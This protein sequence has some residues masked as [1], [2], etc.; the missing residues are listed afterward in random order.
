MHTGHA[1]DP[2]GSRAATGRRF[3]PLILHRPALRYEKVQYLRPDKS[4]DRGRRGR[5]DCRAPPA[6]PYA[7]PQGDQ[8]AADQHRPPNPAIRTHPVIVREVYKR[9]T[10]RQ[11][12]RRM[13]PPVGK[14]AG[15]HAFQPASI[16]NPGCRTGWSD[17]RIQAAELRRARLQT[18][19]YSPTARRLP[20][21]DLLG[22]HNRGDS[23]RRRLR[24]PS[25][26]SC[27]GPRHRGS[28]IRRLR[29]QPSCL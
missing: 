10:P 16:A 13:T 1:L 11:L 12:D 24:E 23:R 28:G 15:C 18:A 9:P 29:R 3:L 21:D 2:A 20:L 26:T 4:T 7:D 19:G 14:A 22:P 6:R 27:P 8:D 25:S 5:V 17:I